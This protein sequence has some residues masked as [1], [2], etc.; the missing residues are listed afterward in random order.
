MK[1]YYSPG[2]C[3]LASHI[4]LNELG[5]EHTIEKVDL[6]AKVTETGVDYKGVNPKGSVPALATAEGVLTEGAAILQFLADKAGNVELAPA[7][8][9]MARA[10]V[11]ELLNFV[12][13]EVHKAY[14][15]LFTP[16]LAEEAKVAAKANI[17]RRLGQLEGML[18]DGRDYLMGAKFSL[19]DAYVF[20]VTNWS[21]MTGVDMSGFPKLEAMRGRVAARPAVQAAMKAEGLIA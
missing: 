4:V 3:S 18:E 7:V 13:T 2:A 1:L 9:T 12:A 20:T 16:G 11:Q 19:A 17:A 21:K 10:R 15:P 6:R 14:S 8:G 5:T